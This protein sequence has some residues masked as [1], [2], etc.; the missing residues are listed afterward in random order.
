MAPERIDK[1]AWCYQVIETFLVFECGIAMKVRRRSVVGLHV[2]ERFEVVT[3]R[4]LPVANSKCLG[5]LSKESIQLR[6][7]IELH[8]TWYLAR[9]EKSRLKFSPFDAVFVFILLV[10]S[11]EES[12][13]AAFRNA[14]ISETQRGPS[15]DMKTRFSVVLEFVT[16]VVVLQECC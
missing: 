13:C 6:S 7:T 16:F 2:F 9:Y 14:M 10:K 5:E 8:H 11:P 15:Q 12:A 1:P 4:W 3:R